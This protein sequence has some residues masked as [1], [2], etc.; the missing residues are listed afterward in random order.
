MQEYG[1]NLES[2]FGGEDPIRHFG[3]D[4]PKAV[5]HVIVRYSQLD[6]VTADSNHFHAILERL[7][8]IKYMLQCSAVVDQRET[9]G[10]LRR[11]RSIEVVDIGRLL[12]FRSIQ[13]RDAL[14][15]NCSK[16]FF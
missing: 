16:E 8:E 9:L 4:L 13:R 3:A 2:V 12:I 10:K 7:R 1:D 5:T 14:G 11:D 6:E 15:T